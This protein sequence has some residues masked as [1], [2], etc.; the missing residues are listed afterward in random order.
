LSSSNPSLSTRLWKH[1][2]RP[3]PKDIGRLPPPK[4]RMNKFGFFC[5][6]KQKSK[7]KQIH[8]FV[9]WE[10]STARQSAYGLSDL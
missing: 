9:F 4:K 10:K 5:H 3:P 6:E 8:S 1:S 2:H 7:K